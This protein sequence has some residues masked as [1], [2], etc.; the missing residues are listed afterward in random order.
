MTGVICTAPSSATAAEACRGQVL[1]SGSYGGEYNAWHAAKWGLRGVILNDAGDGR[2][3]AGIRGLDYLDRIGLPA[4]AADAAT[5]HIGDGEHMLAVG[6][7]SFV[8]SAASKLG[9]RPGESVRACAERMTH[10]PIVDTALPAI[11]GGKRYVMTGGRRPVICLDA[12][13]MLEFADAGSIAI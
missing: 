7:I 4:A 6:R 1:V 9:C 2:D 10:A 3:N 12:A 5:C 11:G 13:P 8:N